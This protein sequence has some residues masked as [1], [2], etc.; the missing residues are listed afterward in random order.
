MGSIETLLRRGQA[1]GL[2]CTVQAGNLRMVGPQTPETVAIVGELARRKNE[3]IQLN[4]LYRRYQEL[5]GRPLISE[6]TR[7][8]FFLADKLGLPKP[9]IQRIHLGARAGE[10]EE[11]QPDEWWP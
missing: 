7:E 11:I 6:E 4:T 10:V 3:V 1:L 8:L 9:V 2:L 5:M